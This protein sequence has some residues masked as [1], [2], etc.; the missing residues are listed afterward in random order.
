M[1]KLPASAGKLW[2]V[3]EKNDDHSIFYFSLFFFSFKSTHCKY[4]NAWFEYNDIVI[5]VNRHYPLDPNA[6]SS[7]LNVLPLVSDDFT[8]RSRGK[9]LYTEITMSLHSNLAF[10]YFQCVNLYILYLGN[11]YKWCPTFLGVFWHPNPP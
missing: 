7:D 3:C 2:K 4:L 8:F 6:K 11:V 1:E 5:S 9:W 10:R